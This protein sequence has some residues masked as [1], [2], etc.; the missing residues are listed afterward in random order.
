ME[1]RYMKLG[2]CKIEHVLYKL[3][4]DKP[5]RGDVHKQKGGIYCSYC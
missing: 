2:S 3:P 4:L 5:L 1:R